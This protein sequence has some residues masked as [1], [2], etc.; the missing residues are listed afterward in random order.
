MG[1]LRLGRLREPSKGIGDRNSG[2]TET[3][4]GAAV[5]TGLLLESGDFFL[6]EDGFFLLL[7]Q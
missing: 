2:F 1:V 6:L 7:E 5:T 4:I 3:A